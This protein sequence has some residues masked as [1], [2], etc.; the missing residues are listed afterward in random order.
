MTRYDRPVQRRLRRLTGI[1]YRSDNLLEII[2]GKCLAISR[3]HV[4][5]YNSSGQGLWGPELEHESY[6]DP[7]LQD[8]GNCLGY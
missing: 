1:C 6:I 2:S 4:P 5:K 7:P 8:E 3:G